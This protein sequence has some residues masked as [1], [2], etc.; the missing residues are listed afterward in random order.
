MFNTST[1]LFVNANFVF[2]VNLDILFFPSQLDY[3]LVVS[4]SLL[5]FSTPSFIF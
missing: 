4:Y 5:M 2:Y 1:L 3:F